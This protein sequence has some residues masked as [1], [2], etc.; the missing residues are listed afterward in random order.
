LIEI[1]RTNN[2]E[3]MQMKRPI[4]ITVFLFACWIS[5]GGLGVVVTAQEQRLRVAEEG[6]GTAVATKPGTTD[7]ASGE[8]LV[9]NRRPLYRIR[10]SDVLEIRFI[11][12]SDFD[13]TVS[14]RPDGFID[15]RGLEE[16]YVEGMTVPELRT[17]IRA[18]YA[19]MLHDP[20]VTLAVKDFDKPYFIATGE[21]ARPGKY[22]LRSDATV[23]EALAIA[24]GLTRQA[25]HSQVVLFRHIS[26]DRVEAKLLN[27]KQMMNSRNLTEDVHIQ[28]GDLLFIPQNRISKVRQ[29]LPASSLNTYLNPT[30]F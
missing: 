20:E 10:K 21:V 22:E 2:G 25:R 18:A 23:T 1:R 12:A 26:D 30:Q 3:A 8:L 27:V 24:G 9:G 16:R 17:A 29:F 7:G 5:Q 14:V 19:P 13:Q 15:L 4:A 28:P 11:F 6:T